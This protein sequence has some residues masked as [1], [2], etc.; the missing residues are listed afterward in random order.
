MNGFLYKEKSERSK[1]PFRCGAEDRNRTGTGVTSH[2]ILSPRRLPVPPLRHSFISLIRI[3]HTVRFVNRYFVICF[4]VPIKIYKNTSLL[5]CV[6]SIT[7]F[8]PLFLILVSEY[9]RYIPYER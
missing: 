2:G 9:S 1:N 7:I 3:A 4:V 6:F 5:S 8:I